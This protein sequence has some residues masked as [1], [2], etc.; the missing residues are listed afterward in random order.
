[1]VQVGARAT[2]VVMGVVHGAGAADDV[3]PYEVFVGSLRATGY[4]GD[5]V[6]GVPRT[7]SDG[8]EEYLVRQAVT[9][10]RL[11]PVA[12]AAAALPPDA[13]HLARVVRSVVRT[14]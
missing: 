12:A 7:L 4:D 10:R 5:V 6:L 11:P 3:V 1:M 13:P 9:L 8:V 2:N 14:K